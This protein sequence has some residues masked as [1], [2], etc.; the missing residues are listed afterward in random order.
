MAMTTS[1][2]IA[3]DDLGEAR[4]AGALTAGP[5]ELQGKG[6]KGG[7]GGRRLRPSGAS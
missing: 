1:E 7:K 3:S 6:G 2:I 5:S 4:Q